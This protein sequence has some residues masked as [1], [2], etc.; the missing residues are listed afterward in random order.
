AIG[1]GIIADV[2]IRTLNAVKGTT[3][4]EPNF[5]DIL[6][7]PNVPPVFGSSVT[8]DGGPWHYSL[9]TWRA[10]LG[11]AF[12]PRLAVVMPTVPLPAIPVIPRGTGLRLPRA[13]QRGPLAEAAHAQA[14]NPD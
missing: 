2:F 10:A 5:S 13:V 7:T 3:I 9:D 14:H 12:S 11:A 4:P 8:S 1:Y 6:F